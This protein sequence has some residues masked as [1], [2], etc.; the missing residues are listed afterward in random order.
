MPSKKKDNDP[1]L[2]GPAPGMEEAE[3]SAPGGETLPKPM[4]PVVTMH[5]VRKYVEA[6]RNRTRRMLLWSGSVFLFVVLCVLVLFISVGIFVLRN[7]RKATEI[8]GELDARTAVYAM[9]IA[10]VSNRLG[11]VERLSADVTNTVFL[12]EEERTREKKVLHSDLK[13][14][15]RWVESLNRKDADMIKRMEARIQELASELQAKEKE[16]D[17]IK[18]KYSN[19]VAS[20][21]SPSRTRAESRS[22]PPVSVDQVEI[23]AGPPDLDSTVEAV[24]PPSPPAQTD[25][26]V[27]YKKV[28][29]PN[30]DRYEGGFK[31]GLFN[32]WGTYYYANGDVYE[33]NFFN[34]M[35]HGR[36]T[37]VF[38][39]GNRYAGE[40]MNDQKHGTG[41]MKFFNGDV[42]E[43]EFQFG[44]RNGQ[45]SYTFAN[46]ARY[47]GEF[48]MN[49]RH[50]QGRYTYP[51]GEEYVG[52]FKNGKKDGRGTCIYPGGQELSGLWK[53]DNFLR[54]IAP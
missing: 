38:A 5:V 33:G 26:D 35:R 23:E 40:W 10:D 9:E 24:N 34:D 4:D 25:E 29:L 42:Y 17:S 7:S 12:A 18:A 50:G 45:G 2:A 20:V 27:E 6:E 46:G 28:V 51:G 49:Q 11:R 15:S 37:M 39:N 32:G 44:N 22:A 19:L 14:F 30:G 31:N 1:T 8:V 3:L 53:D 48:R 41:V 43:G 36:G 52:E 47:V 21:S 13:R 16:F 54:P